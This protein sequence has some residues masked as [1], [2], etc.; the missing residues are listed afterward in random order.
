MS[1]EIKNNLKQHLTDTRQVLWDAIDG[2]QD[3]EWDVQVQ[4]DGAQWTVLQM[5]RHLQD[6]ERGL[7]GQTMRITKGE[8]SVPKDFDPDRWNNRIQQKTTEMT[9]EEAIEVLKTSREKLLTFID[10]IPDEAWQHSGYQPGLKET[11]SL[12]Q[13]IKVIGWHEEG[14]AKEIAAA[15]ATHRGT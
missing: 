3:D 6:A 14:H 8:E 4:A 11:I 15:L 12:E 9:A 5:M 1:D 7:R 13:F 2:I 10:T